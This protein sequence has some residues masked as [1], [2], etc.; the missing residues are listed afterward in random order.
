MLNL[1]KSEDQ[2]AAVIAHEIAHVQMKHGV[3]AI[4]TS[5]IAEAILASGA[6]DEAKA[7]QLAK[8]TGL[9]REEVTGIFAQATGEMTAAL[10]NK[11][12]AQ[13]QEYNA[14][15]TALSL[16]ASAGYS[17]QGLS[18]MLT[19]MGKSQTGKTGMAGTHPSAQD[20]LEAVQKS[21]GYFP[22]KDTRQ[23]RTARFT[24][25]F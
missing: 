10:V 16:L 20:R 2:L 15:Y 4:Q 7:G 19:E 9:S 12:Y 17:P 25:A 5:R 8:A 22:V 1:A 14:D 13:V 24:A 6:S 18:E 23:Y 21:I 3:K 11:G